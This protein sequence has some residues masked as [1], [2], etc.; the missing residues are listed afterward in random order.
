MY[1]FREEEKPRFNIQHSGLVGLILAALLLWLLWES[2]DV[3]SL[4]AAELDVLQELAEQDQQQERPMTFRFM[5]APEDDEEV[6]AKFLSDANRIQKAPVPDAPNEDPDPFSE[7]NTYELENAPEL[8]NQ[9]RP[10]VPVQPQPSFMDRRPSHEAT[11]TPPP[12]QNEPT[13]QPTEVEELQP[14]EV[15]EPQDNPNEEEPREVPETEA[16][17]TSTTELPNEPEPLDIEGSSVEA[18]PTEIEKVGKE[19][20]GQGTVPLPPNAPKPYK[21]MSIEEQLTARRE[22]AQNMDFTHGGA[23][24]V[25]GARYNNPTGAGSPNLGLTVETNRSDMGPYL[26]ILKQLVQGNWRI[27]NIARFEV[28]GVTGISFKIHKDGRISDVQV[29]LTSRYEPLDVAALN[30]INNTDPA[31][32]LPQHVEEDFV[33]IKFG[34]YYNMRPRY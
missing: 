16:E 15:E 31:P 33:P 9:P 8:A 23:R 11:L 18:E 30:A 12:E 34:F 32:P 4:S 13:A 20:P 3:F 10:T 17:E 2:K 7:G 26:K 28:A 27:P 21:K 29:A 22:A 5:E 14:E 19:A 1:L 25:Q 6:D 24:V